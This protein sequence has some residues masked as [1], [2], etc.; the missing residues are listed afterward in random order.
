MGVITVS[1]HPGSLGDT[2][3]RGL[4]ERLQYRLVE[5]AELIQLAERIG[6]PDIA[7]DR[8]P[9][10]RERS[11]SFWERLN[12]ELSVET[13][14]AQSNMSPRNFARA[15]S[16]ETGVTPAKAVERLRLESARERVEHSSDPID[17]VA[18]DVGF[19]IDNTQQFVYAVEAGKTTD[20]TNINVTDFRHEGAVINAPGGN[21]N[22][23]IR[24]DDG[25]PNAP[26][27]GGRH[28]AVSGVVTFSPAS[29]IEQD[30]ESIDGD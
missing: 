15:F 9:E 29:E 20:F 30:A 24:Y 7:W 14:A 25:G 27:A 10:L 22:W 6:G 11:P 3:A 12:E 18:Q 23:A 2:L 26:G 4:A 19:F 8:S 16:A 17:V 13:L 1:R 28:L 5:R 21:D